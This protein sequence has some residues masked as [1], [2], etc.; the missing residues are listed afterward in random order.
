MNTPHRILRAA[1]SCATPPRCRL[2]DS[3]RR[4]ERV[5][6]I[7]AA[8]AQTAADY[9]ALVCVFMFGGN[10][11]NNTVIPLDAAG[12]GQYA[13]IRTAASS[14]QLAQS[15]LLPIQ[16]INMGTP[17]GLHPALAELQTLFNQRK[18][19]DRRQC[20][21]A[22]RTDVAGAIRRGTAAAVALLARRP[23]GAV[24]KRD[25]E[26]R[27]RH[28]LGRPPGRRRGLL[29]TPAR[30]FRSSLRSMAPCCSRRAR[31]RFHCRFR[32]AAH[33]RSQGTTAARPRPRA[34]R[35]SRRCSATDAGNTYTRQRERHRRAGIACCPAMVNPIL[36]NANS[37]VAPL[38]AGLDTN[39]ARQLFQVAKMIEARGATGARAADLLRAIGQLRH[40]QRPA[41]PPAE[42]VRRTGRLR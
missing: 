37:T 36:A 41:Q 5:S 28:R 31:R 29:S 1:R 21:H 13:A 15:S 17:Y 9:K 24:A 2:W 30:A 7:G 34:S 6:A 10:D 8:N 14:I 40:A 35:R 16:P 20:R 38:F 12:Y 4:F 42:S 26:Q 39:T 33:S 3:R 19:G 23:A 27:R 18:V 11:G 22:A 32:S 25:L